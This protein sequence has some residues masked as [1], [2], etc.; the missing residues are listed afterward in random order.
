MAN[1]LFR[2]YVQGLMTGA[3]TLNLTDGNVKVVLVDTADDDP[4]ATI[5]GDEFLSDILAAGREATT[6]ALVNPTVTDGVF[7]ADDITL[8]DDGGDQAEELIVFHDTTVETTS[9]LIMRI[10]TATGLPI[11]PDN[12]ADQIA[13]NASGIFAL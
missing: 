2:K 1:Q 10:D 5:T 7:D 13:W 8:P 12:V 9:R 11:T 3:F 6:A 4:D